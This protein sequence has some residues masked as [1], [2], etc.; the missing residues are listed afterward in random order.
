MCEMSVH[1]E[2]H[3]GPE[4]LKSV[5]VYCT[6]NADSATNIYRKITGVYASAS[7]PKTVGYM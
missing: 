4:K 3:N 7:V 1:V 6:A 2:H 5:L